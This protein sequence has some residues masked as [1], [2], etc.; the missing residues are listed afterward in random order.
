MATPEIVQTPDFVNRIL[1]DAVL[2]YLTTLFGTGAM[3]IFSLFRGFTGS[4]PALKRLMPD[5][6]MV[7][8]DRL[9]FLILVFSGSVIGT[10]FFQPKDTLQALAAGFGWV[11]AVNVLLSQ[12][13]PEHAPGNVT[14]TH[15]PKEPPQTEGGK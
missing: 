2:R 11:G 3:Y 13:P 4:V 14:T 12:K 5:R 6:T 10:I 15:N 7:F 8:Y 1:S 9:D